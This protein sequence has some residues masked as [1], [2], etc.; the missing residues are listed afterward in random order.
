MPTPRKTPPKAAPAPR[1]RK[2]KPVDPTPAP[3]PTTPQIKALDLVMSFDTTGSMAGA[4]GQAKEAGIALVADLFK[5]NPGIRIAIVSHG[6]YCDYRNNSGGPITTAAMNSAMSLPN[7]I[8]IADFSSNLI[9]I[10]TAIEHAPKTGGGDMP[11]CYEV[12]YRKVRYLS[13]RKDSDKMMLQFSDAIPH[14]ANFSENTHK[15]DYREELAAL[16]KM[17]VQVSAIHCLNNEREVIAYQ[18]EIASIT[19][20]KYFTLKNWTDVLPMIK[21]G[22]IFQSQGVAG[23]ETYA[24]DLRKS[25]SM[26]ADLR[27]ATTTYSKGTV[28][29]GGLKGIPAGRFMVMQVPAGVTYV[30]GVKKLVKPGCKIEEFVLAQGITY[31]PGNG[32]YEWT[33]KEKHVQGYKKVVVQRKDTGE[34][35]EGERARKLAG[36]PGSGSGTSGGIADAVLVAPPGGTQYRFFVES[37]SMN[38]ILIPGTHFLYLAKS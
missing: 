1:K 10:K 8:T 30:S 13:W 32:F 29:K 36:L 9:E 11:E 35:Y 14:P 12:A 34:C 15:I 24:E 28:S 21:M 19:G 27:S 5:I 7:M 20:G 25:G 17:G 38:R 18:Q 33:K 2:T 16:G 22:V 37:D 3:G 26:S 31:E 6:D 4:I 23:V